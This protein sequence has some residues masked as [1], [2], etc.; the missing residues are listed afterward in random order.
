MLFVEAELV[1]LPSM[2]P[3]FSFTLFPSASSFSIYLLC[4]FVVFEV[5]L[6]SSSFLSRF[7]TSELAA[8]RSEWISSLR[9][10]S[11]SFSSLFPLLSLFLSLLFRY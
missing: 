1:E 5:L 2:Q 11:S 6:M 10:V 8:E 4:I 7:A 9:V 3:F